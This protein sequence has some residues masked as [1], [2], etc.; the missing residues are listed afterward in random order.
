M[1]SFLFAFRKS[2]LGTFLTLCVAV[3]FVMPVYAGISVV[4]DGTPVKLD[5]APVRVQ[6]QILLPAAPLF[7]AFGAK[8]EWDEKNR[9]ISASTGEACVKIQIGAETATINGKSVRLDTPA[10][11]INGQAYISAKFLAESF[12]ARVD[13]VADTETVVITGSPRLRQAIA[14]ES[15]PK[16]QLQNAVNSLTGAFSMEISDVNY[17]VEK[18]LNIN[19]FSQVKNWSYEGIKSGDK[20]ILTWTLELFDEHAVIEAY[21]NPAL[22]CKLTERQKTL[23][24]E[25]KLII[26]KIISPYMTSYK[27]Q[28]AIHNYIVL[29]CSYDN[30]L[31][32]SNSASGEEDSF[33]AYGA[34]I[35]GKAVCAGYT[36]AA[37]ILLTM[38]GIENYRLNSSEHS[39]NLV[40]LD[41]GY[42]HMDV[43]WDDPSPDVR[44]RVRYDYFNLTDAEIKQYKMHNWLDKKDYPKA[45]ATKYNYFVYNNLVA[46]NYS[47][48][49]QMLLKA[50]DAGTG[51]ITIVVADYQTGGYNWEEDLSF[52]LDLSSKDHVTKFSYSPPHKDRA[53]LTVIF[54]H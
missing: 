8:M 46:H 4:V 42:Y 37:R 36:E 11:I 24:K 14:A 54:G 22:E 31:A 52:L 50:V 39:W 43:T 5:A 13:W 38:A 6:S 51:Q 10:Q 47:E 20:I 19:E 27:K 44:G 29:N 9:T 53:T 16:A 45:T 3:V 7:E 26:N 1:G 41:D 35:N 30:E 2:L 32:M 49:K 17:D 33:F 21:K 25:C 48:L 15:D 23:L 12:G 18:E 28:L 34:L 40:K